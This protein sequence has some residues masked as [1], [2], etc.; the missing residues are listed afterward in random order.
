MD[1]LP[2]LGELDAEPLE[3][4]A[5]QAG[6]E[7]LDDGPC[8]QLERAQPRDDGR[9]EKLAPRRLGHVVRYI[10]L[11]GTG[12]ASISRSTMTSGVMRSDS[13]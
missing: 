11:F 9:I 12:T 1:V 3:G 8:L 7:A 4:A 13:A 2:V 10:P 5:V 6:Q